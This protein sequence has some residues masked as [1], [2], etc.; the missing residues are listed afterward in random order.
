LEVVEALEAA[1][2][3]SM[4][5]ETVIQ[6]RKREQGQVGESKMEGREERKEERRPTVLGPF[7]VE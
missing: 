2:G 6:E 4:R 5:V 1:V 3:F 7:N